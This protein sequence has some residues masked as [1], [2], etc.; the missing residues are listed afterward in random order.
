MLYFTFVFSWT[1]YCCD[2]SKWRSAIN[3]VRGYKNAYPHHN[4]NSKGNRRLL[5]NALKPTAKRN[6]FTRKIT[7]DSKKIR[8]FFKYNLISAF[9][10]CLT[11]NA[12]HSNILMLLHYYSPFI[13]V[14]AQ[15]KKNET[16]VFPNINKFTKWNINYILQSNEEEK[17]N[18]AKLDKSS[19]C[20]TILNRIISKADIDGKKVI[21][22]VIW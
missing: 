14:S 19:K 4:S 20:I 9:F 12:F 21:Q 5:E 1:K 8:Y 10:L 22:I 16:K 11:I 2:W 18:L 15:R 13:M 17:N 3:I 6:H 7:E